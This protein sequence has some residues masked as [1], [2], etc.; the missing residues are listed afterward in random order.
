MVRRLVRP[1]GLLQPQRTVF[2]RSAQRTRRQ[3]GQ[4]NRSVQII[5][6]K[7]PRA[8]GER[9]LPGLSM[10][11]SRLIATGSPRAA[12]LVRTQSTRVLKVKVKR[13]QR[14]VLPA[15]VLAL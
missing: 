7:G 2:H 12:R 5:L 6:P 11:W 9:A 8:R 3:L 1:I 13:G 4:P 14:I 10:R 15:E